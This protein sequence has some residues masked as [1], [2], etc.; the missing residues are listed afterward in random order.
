M[1]I[2]HRAKTVPPA[3]MHPLPAKNALPAH[4][5]KSAS[6]APHVRTAVHAMVATTHHGYANCV[7]RSMRRPRV[8][9]ARPAKSALLVKSV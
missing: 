3:R 8:K 2:V 9:N 6:R 4:R 5:V 7:N 1:K